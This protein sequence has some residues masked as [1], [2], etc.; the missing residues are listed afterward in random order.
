MKA[1]I[2][3]KWKGLYNEGGSEWKWLYNKSE[4][5]SDYTMKGR[6]KLLHTESASESDYTMKGEW[7]RLY[8]G[9]ESKSESKGGYM[10]VKL[11]VIIQWKWEWK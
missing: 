4:C 2:Q 8:T 10:K 6:V 3:W 9:N 5:G 7:N 1:N 11:T